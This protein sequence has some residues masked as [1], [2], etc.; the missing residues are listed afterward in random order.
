MIL[1]SASTWGHMANIDVRII[2]TDGRQVKEVLYIN[3]QENQIVYSH[4]DVFGSGKNHVTYHEDGYVHRKHES[5]DG[6]VKQVPAVQGPPLDEFKGFFGAHQFQIRT[7]MSAGQRWGQT[8][9]DF[10]F[11]QTD[12]V[13]YMDIRN[14]GD[15]INIHP[16]FIEVGK[17][18]TDVLDHPGSEVEDPQ[19][20]YHVITETDPWTAVAYYSLDKWRGFL[21]PHSR[22]FVVINEE[23]EP[24]PEDTFGREKIK[25]YR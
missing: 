20:Q 13:I 2:A 15:S 8:N 16:Y 17:P 12:A 19:L 11:S 5:P 9:P 4:Q 14:A 3:H 23:K 18:F 1:S 25:E 24:Y 21:Q 22:D 6:S 10:D 7:S